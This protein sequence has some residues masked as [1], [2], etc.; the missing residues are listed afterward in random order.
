[1]LH[2][3]RQALWAF[4]FHSNHQGHIKMGKK[5]TNKKWATIPLSDKCFMNKTNGRLSAYRTSFLYVTLMIGTELESP[6]S[7]TA[8]CRRFLGFP[9]QRTWQRTANRSNLD[10]HQI[11]SEHF[12]CCPQP[13]WSNPSTISPFGARENPCRWPSSQNFPLQN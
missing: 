6:K 5:H 1:M 4:Q 8:C 3:V 2:T 10:L 11:S 13:T 7:R 9:A 12:V